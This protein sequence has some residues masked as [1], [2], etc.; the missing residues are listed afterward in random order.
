MADQGETYE[1]HLRARTWRNGEELGED[2]AGGYDY[3][4]ACL[5]TVLRHLYGEDFTGY[6]HNYLFRDGVAYEQ[7][8]GDPEE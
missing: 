3:R 2:E 8:D 6:D 1:G 5:C 7:E 4:D